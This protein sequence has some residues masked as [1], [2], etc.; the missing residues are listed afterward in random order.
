MNF[1]NNCRT[2]N[3]SLLEQARKNLEI[4]LYIVFERSSSKL[5]LHELYTLSI[6]LTKYQARSSSRATL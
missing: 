2:R 5:C 4:F 6:F 3:L 1:V